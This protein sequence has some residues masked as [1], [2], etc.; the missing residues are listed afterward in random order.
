MFPHRFTSPVS[1]T[2]L[3][4]AS[5]AAEARGLTVRP[6]GFSASMSGLGGGPPMK[7]LTSEEW[8]DVRKKLAPCRPLP[9]AGRFEPRPVTWIR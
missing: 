3:D 2:A 7:S 8:A 4:C 5:P 1:V 6:F 9:P